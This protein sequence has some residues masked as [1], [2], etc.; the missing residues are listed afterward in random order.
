MPRFA[1]LR[2]DERPASQRRLF[3]PTRFCR[4]DYTVLYLVA[5]SHAGSVAEGFLPIVQPFLP[6][7]RFLSTAWCTCLRYGHQHRSGLIIKCHL[8]PAW[9]HSQSAMMS[10]T[11]TSP[12]VRPFE[13]CAGTRRRAL[14]DRSC[15]SPTPRH[16]TPPPA[17]QQP[18]D[19]RPQRRRSIRCVLASRSLPH[20]FALVA[21]R[22]SRELLYMYIRRY[23]R[24]TMLPS[25][26]SVLWRSGLIHPPTSPA[27]PVSVGYL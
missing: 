16:G 15:S 22:G 2:L 3:T 21:L 24:S 20:V 1:L 10:R 11:A 6:H 23:T 4:V 18:N 26:A 19:K 25:Q 8:R 9:L 13:A 5:S 17:L 7:V 27:A 12:S 14:A